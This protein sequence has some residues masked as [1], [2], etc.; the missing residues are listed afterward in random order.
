MQRLSAPAPLRAIAAGV[1]LVVCALLLA[2]AGRAQ[3]AELFYW[4]NYKAKPQ[5]ISFANS[6]GSGG[7]LLNLTGA[8][9][10]GP[11][12]MAIDTVTG[13]LYVA[14]DNGGPA[15]KGEILFA[16]LDGSGAG[17]FSAPGAP[18]EAP[19]GV[20]VDP[21]TRMIYWVNAEG[22]APAKGSIAWA[23]LDGSA[24]GVLNTTG[25]TLSGPYKIA[26]DPV[27]GRVYW[28]NNGGADVL[29]SYAN[30]NNTGGADLAVTPAPKSVYAMAV[31]PA[32]GRLYISEGE[33]ERFAYT[34]L[35]GGPLNLLN[36]SPAVT[37]AS[38]GFAVDPTLNR[39]VW[40]NYDN[41]AERLNGLG[42]ASLGGGGGGN[43][44][45]ATAPFDGPQDLLV[46]KS[47]TGTAAPVITRGKGSRSTLNCPT[48]TWAADFAGSF[49][50]QSPTTYAYQWALNGKA[51]A[52]ATAS[53]L[54][55][56]KPGKYTCA[57]N[58]TNQAGAASQTSAAAVVKASK[59]K[60]T[61]K[62]KVTVKAGG[63]A[64][65]PIKVANQGD[66]KSKNAK[67]CVL[68]PKAA[69]GALK[70]PKCKSLGKLKGKG[71]KSAKLK[72][73]ALPSA[74]GVY[75]VSFKVKGSAGKAAKAKIVVK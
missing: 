30:V 12:G 54:K 15:K 72:I 20:V 34:G 49:V 28:G 70:A 16:N 17:V 67:L 46:L 3:A 55:A 32:A 43:I 11:E 61:T 36:T 9:L 39:I 5:T 42:F 14:S 48:G 74:S 24:G 19:E 65:F 68:L 10:D 59:A 45:P 57:V 21:V 56:S 40:P 18:V 50:Y 4:D 2:L 51:V 75:A 33:A 52:A 7:G 47:P 8:T 64:T 25:A 69:K 37:T 58:A 27:S 22:P 35:L 63:T 60:L 6:D 31:D 44:S 53:T 66:L 13:R 23:K 26:L 71:K 38:Y 1:L 29:I 73:K 62:K 41:G